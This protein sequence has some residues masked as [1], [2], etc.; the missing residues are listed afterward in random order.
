MGMGFAP[1]WLRQVS[2]P[3]SQNHFN[4]CT[5]DL[6]LIYRPWR[7]GRLSRPWCE[8]APV[9][10]RTYNLP[11]ANPALYHTA[12]SVLTCAATTLIC[13]RMYVGLDMTMN[14]AEYDAEM[15]QPG[16]QLQSLSNKAS[17]C[18]VTAAAEDS[19]GF[20][21]FDRE[22]T[23]TAAGDLSRYSIRNAHLFTSDYNE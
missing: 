2:P 18:S 23:L 4:H 22:E 8:V 7:D 16:S 20:T 10:I 9:E 5:C 21:Q 19:C 11:I 17:F 15:D 14:S 6:V 1:T 3:A 13:V 12:T